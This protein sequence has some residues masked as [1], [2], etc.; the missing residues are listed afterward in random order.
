MFEL[1]KTFCE[2]PGPV[3]DEIAVQ[4]FL[5]ERW[6]P[7]GY[8][9]KTDTGRQSH[10]SIGGEG[11]RLMI[12]A[13]ADKI[14]FVVKHI[15]ADGFLDHDRSARCRAA[16]QPAQPRISTLG[17]SGVGRDRNRECGRS[18]CDADRAR[19]DCRTARQEQSGL[20]RY[21]CGCG[22]FQSGRRGSQGN[23][24]G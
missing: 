3:G 15:A 13:H 18:L 19:P 8:K 1:L 7:R 9:T 5:M 23:P 16:T 24:S 21:L 20:A 2:L 10:R 22:R 6:R 4:N 14:C 17:A 12:A 11:P